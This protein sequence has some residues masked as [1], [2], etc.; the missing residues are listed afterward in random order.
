MS[1]PLLVKGKAV[2]LGYLRFHS[3]RYKIVRDEEMELLFYEPG[4]LSVTHGSNWNRKK[5]ADPLRA[6]LSSLIC[7]SEMEDDGP[8]KDIWTAEDI[9]IN[10]SLQRE[11]WKVES[12]PMRTDIDCEV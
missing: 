2:A 7:F 4:K 6:L 9:C 5:V 10:R 1:S 12:C 11:A 8:V 3:L